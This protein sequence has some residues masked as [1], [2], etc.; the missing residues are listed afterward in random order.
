MRLSMYLATGTAGV[1]LALGA[2]LADEP[3]HLPFLEPLSANEPV[4]WV[5]SQVGADDCVAS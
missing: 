3:V 5:E 1:L 2:A 4:P